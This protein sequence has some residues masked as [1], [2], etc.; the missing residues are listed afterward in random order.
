MRK[1]NEKYSRKIYFINKRFQIFFIFRIALGILLSTVFF[2]AIIFYLS[3]SGTTVVFKNFRLEVLPTSE[4]IFS[5][6][7]I[8]LIIS[9]LVSFSIFFILGLKYSHQISGPMFRFE[10]IFKNLATGEF[11]QVVE[12]RRNDEWKKTALCLNEALDSICDKMKGL[13]NSFSELKNV[14]E[15]NNDPEISKKISNV[16][17]SINQFHF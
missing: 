5:S 10:T 2:S 4:F 15:V 3:T 17:N 13:N 12:L 14:L 11:K 9:I 7:S 6:L 8:G 1:N 16:Q